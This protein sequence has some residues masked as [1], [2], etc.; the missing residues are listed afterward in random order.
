MCM[1]LFYN[2]FNNFVVFTETET[3]EKDEP[4]KK[5]RRSADPKKWKKMFVS[6]EE[7]L[8]KNT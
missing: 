2:I 6:Y 3:D 5:K 1:L 7:Q 8:V 4:V